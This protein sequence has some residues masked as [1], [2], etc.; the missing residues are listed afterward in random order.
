MFGNLFEDGS[1]MAC[2][3]AKS[4]LSINGK[5]IEQPP[6]E[7]G[8]QSLIGIQNQ[9]ATCYLNSLIQTLFLTPEFRE[10]LFDI[11]CEELGK[12][13]PNKKDGK[14]RKIPLQLQL[15]F[16]RLLLINQSSCKTEDLT[17]S[18]G[19]RNSEEMQQHDVQ[20]LSRILFDAIENSLVG[21]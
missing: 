4:V 19:W 3:N 15:L 9:G 13:G 20:E 21:T 10:Q 6:E 12:S 11:G 8:E 5:P 18:F 1:N 7:R 2:R 16:A 14:V 17:D